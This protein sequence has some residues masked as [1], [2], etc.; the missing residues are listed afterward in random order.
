VDRLRPSTTL[1]HAQDEREEIPHRARRS[2]AWLRRT[3]RAAAAQVAAAA[4]A[5]GALAGCRDPAAGPGRLSGALPPLP[6]Y[7]A[8]RATSP[9]TID[10]RVSEEAWRAA[11]V[12]DLVESLGGG[13]PRYR[14]RARM[15]WDDE[16]L[17]VAFECDDDLV[18]ARPGRRDDD[19]LWEDEVVEVFLDPAGGGRG[20]VEVE[21]SPANVRFDARFASWR[22][23]LAAARAFDARARTATAVDG[24]LTL[25]DAPAAA[26]RGWSAELAL[27]WRAL[28]PDARPRS[29][30]RWRVNLYRLETHNRRGVAEGSA[31]SPPLRG[32]F[33]A[34]DRFGWLELR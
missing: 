16:A 15:L 24:A 26:A 4:L 9:V 34:L 11:P 1:R 33:H 32:D 10:G 31:F 14:T 22:S 27:P 6:T 25:G 30:L 20:Y 7:A 2:R 19:P 21:L 28:A 12:V 17:Y 8:P 13:E 5:A 3:V 29:G 18:W 23:D